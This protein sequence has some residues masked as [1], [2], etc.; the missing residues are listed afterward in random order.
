MLPLHMLDLLNMFIH[1]NV[2]FAGLKPRGRG[3]GGWSAP[4]MRPFV[5]LSEGSIDMLN[6]G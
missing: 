5:H 4:A 3:D 6:I 2:C 1:L